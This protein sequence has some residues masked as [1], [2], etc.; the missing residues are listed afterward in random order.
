MDKAQYETADHPSNNGYTTGYSGRGYKARR[1]EE[2]PSKTRKEV[3]PDGK[4][5]YD[6]RR[7]EVSKGSSNGG[8]QKV[9]HSILL[10][11]LSC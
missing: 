7:D 3:T 5:D 8:K 11:V 2:T 6:R 4:Q 10:V 1:R 9:S